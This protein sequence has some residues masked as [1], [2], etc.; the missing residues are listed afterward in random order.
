MSFYP[1]LTERKVSRREDAGFKSHLTSGSFKRMYAWEY[2]VQGQYL[3]VCSGFTSQEQ[4]LGKIKLSSPS[5]DS[6]M[7]ISLWKSSEQQNSGL[8]LFCH[9]G[10]SITFRKIIDT[11]KFRSLNR[12]KKKEI[13][14][15]G[16]S[17]W[18]R[19]NHDLEI[20]YRQM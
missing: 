10:Y 20:F 18:Q 6:K 8:R 19:C 14:L 11:K 7:E 12:C 5:T 13:H 15:L 4:S 16:F 9:L 17:N 1:V 2:I 3:H